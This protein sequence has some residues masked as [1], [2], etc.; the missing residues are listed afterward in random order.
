MGT[1]IVIGAANF[2]AHELIYVRFMIRIKTI[3]KEGAE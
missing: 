2:N 1:V 3:F